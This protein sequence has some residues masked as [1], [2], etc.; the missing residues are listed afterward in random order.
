MP[1]AEAVAFSCAIYDQRPV[2]CRTYPWSDAQILFPSCQFVE[3]G[4]VVEFDAA[5][6]RLGSRAAVEEACQSCG[7]CCYAWQQRG[8]AL[9]PVIRCEHLVR[10]VRRVR[11]GAD[12]SAPEPDH[13]LMEAVQAVSVFG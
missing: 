2:S 6:A 4:Q 1:C 11:S 5:V 9:T 3:D 12:A 7:R 13:A 10:R 8:A